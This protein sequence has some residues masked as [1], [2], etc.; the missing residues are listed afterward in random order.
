MA[1][2]GLAGR[3]ASSP[4]TARR[5]R[6]TTCGAVQ[7]GRAGRAAVDTGRAAWNRSLIGA[8]G[9]V[10]A[11]GNLTDIRGRPVIDRAWCWRWARQASCRRS[12]STATAQRLWERG[13]GSQTPWAAGHSCSSP[14]ANADVATVGPQQR[15]GEV[16][17]AAHPITRTPSAGNRC[18]GRAGAG[19]RSLLVAGT[20]GDLLALALH[21]RGPRQARGARS[22][23]SR[24]GDRQSHGL[25]T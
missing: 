24:P 8:R 9:E 3:Q 23:A 12:I 4:A 22:G 17:D 2:L 25:R 10:R 1:V 21:R 14:P 13:I 7:L 16:G 5:D 20:L 15:Q 11:F 6:A 18:S 19:R